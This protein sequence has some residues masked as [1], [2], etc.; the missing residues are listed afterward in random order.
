[1]GTTQSSQA[2]ALYNRVVGSASQKPT[3]VIVVSSKNSTAS[4]QDF[5]VFV[6]RL[7]AKVGTSPGITNV[8][9]NFGLG[10]PT[11]LG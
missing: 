10:Q 7:E 3:D 8:A 2:E 11:G 4:D 1:M 5:K 9:A 6:S